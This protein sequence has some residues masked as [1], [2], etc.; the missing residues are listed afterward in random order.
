MRDDH[1][2]RLKAAH[3]T[4]LDE[5]RQGWPKVISGAM[6]YGS[7]VAILTMT[8]GLFVK[9]MQADL[10]WS[11][12]EVSLIPII[13][14]VMALFNPF[15]GVLVDRLGSRTVFLYGLLIFAAGMVAL[16]FA[17]ATRSS[18]YVIAIL[19][20]IVAPATSSVPVTKGIA[21][22]FRTSAGTAFGV[23]LNGN[24]VVAL[25][26]APL[27]SAALFAYGWRAG[28]LTIAAVVIFL[29][30]LPV[31][32]WFR[33][34]GSILANANIVKPSPRQAM[35]SAL[36]D[37]RFWLLL[38][39]FVLAAFP[40]GGFVTQLAPIALEKGLGV[41]AATLLTMTY[42]IS[43]SIGRIGGGLMLDRFWD[44]G[45]AALLL[46]LAGAGGFMLYLMTASMPPAMAFFSVFLLGMGHGAEVDFS[47]YFTLK[48][49]GFER[50]STVLGIYAMFMGL[51]MS[52]GAL[53]FAAAADSFKNYELAI[54][55]GSL[56]YIT[57]GLIIMLLRLGSRRPKSIS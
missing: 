23:T 28:F 24:A 51:G 38:I 50:Y 49:F 2:G 15:I 13:G 57:S 8:A 5:W 26:A 4:A 12:K 52:G 55:I 33:E 21:T 22:W 43:V 40:L 19:I 45:V 6:G 30:V 41:T 36:Y 3:S 7:G 10:G 46:T 16:A 42:A 44:G 14:L 20:G 39:A 17:P 56:C 34:R 54:W 31:A 11:T 25:F 53:A 18:I 1:D 37:R 48:M 29:G 9:P 35:A 27:I 47:A 32:I